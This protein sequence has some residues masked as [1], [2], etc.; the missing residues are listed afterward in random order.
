MQSVNV[1]GKLYQVT[2]HTGVKKSVPHILRG[3]VATLPQGYGACGGGSA[4]GMTGVSKW[5][6]QGHL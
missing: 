5:P 3:G 2:S 1:L 4:D 6:P